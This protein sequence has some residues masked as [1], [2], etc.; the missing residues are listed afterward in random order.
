MGHRR[1]VTARRHR[2][3]LIVDGVGVVNS[4]AFAPDGS[5]VALATS[6]GLV[7][8]I[9]DDR[10]SHPV[11]RA[12][13]AATST[14]SPS[15]RTRPTVASAMGERRG[16]E[17]FDDTVT[18]FDAGSGGEAG[19]FGG[20]AEQVAGCAFFR[21]EVRFS[22]DGDAAGRQLARL[23]GVAL[24]RVRRRDPAHVP[25]AR[26]HRDRP[27]VLAGRRAA[28]DRVRRLDVACLVGRRS[29]AGEGVHDAAGRLLVV[30][31]RRR[32]SHA[33]RQ[34]RRRDRQ[35]ARRRHRARSCA[36]SSARRTASPSWRSPPTARSWRPA[37]TTT[38]SSCGR[39]RPASSLAQLPGHTSPVRTVAFSADGTMLASGSS[40]ATVR[41]WALQATS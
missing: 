20:E 16:P 22:P 17:S 14:R 41:L 34:R 3:S 25:A 31:V 21:N 6:S 12:A 33:R 4:V 7:E 8:T 26:E 29:P 30:G 5:S 32:W 38:P 37:P 19:Q 9:D 40:D 18:I 2:P 10:R 15:R 39:P 23:H 1:R 11:V 27:R 13:D 28:G 24:R 36:R 35:R